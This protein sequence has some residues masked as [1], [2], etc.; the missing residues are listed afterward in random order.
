M[1]NFADEVYTF[2]APLGAELV[3]HTAWPQFGGDPDADAPAG[4]ALTLPAFS[5]ALLPV[6][7]THLDVYKR[8][9]KSLYDMDE[10]TKPAGMLSINRLACVLACSIMLYS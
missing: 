8:Q 6:S 7:Y 9:I 3:L 5:A 4:D 10:P 2:D 1:C